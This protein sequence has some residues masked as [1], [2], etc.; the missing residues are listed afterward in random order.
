[1]IQQGDFCWGQI[2][3]GQI[4]DF[5]RFWFLFACVSV[6]ASSPSAFSPTNFLFIWMAG[7]GFMDKKV[8]FSRTLLEPNV[9][10]VLL[11]LM[12]GSGMDGWME[13]LGETLNA[14]LLIVLAAGKVVIA[15]SLL[16]LILIALWLI[17]FLLLGA[18]TGIEVSIS[19][20]CGWGFTSGT[21]TVLRTGLWPIVKLV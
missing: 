16:P 6:S 3:F 2:V 11:V 19:V 15:G 12:G 4:K 8:G 21:N 14:G 7:E 17:F 18:H 13:Q 1:M 9:I 5:D 20:S 10:G